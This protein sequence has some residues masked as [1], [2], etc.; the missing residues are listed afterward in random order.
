MPDQESINALQSEFATETE[1]S[2]SLDATV[3]GS[4]LTSRWNAFAVKLREDVNQK[5]L[6]SD[7]R[8][9]GD[10]PVD[11]QTSGSETTIRSRPED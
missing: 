10:H 11:N 5:V 7:E 9:V 3:V 6:S 4:H 8:H 1:P 2:P